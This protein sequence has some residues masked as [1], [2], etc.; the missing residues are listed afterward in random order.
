MPE[1]R[2]SDEELLELSQLYDLDICLNDGSVMP[3]SRCGGYQC[4]KCS[5][6]FTAEGV[7]YHSIALE[8]RRE[9][10]PIVLELIELRKAKQLRV[11]FK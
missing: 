5:F 8:V 4:E 11:D 6:H 2:I 3:S 7:E 1:S 9:Y 10:I